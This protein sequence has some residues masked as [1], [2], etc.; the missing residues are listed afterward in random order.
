MAVIW[1]RRGRECGG[2]AVVA[3]LASFILMAGA[4]M[5]GMAD[6]AQALTLRDPDPETFVKVSHPSGLTVTMGV[7]GTDSDGNHY[8]CIEA[9]NPVDNEEGSVRRYQDDER[10]RRMAWILDRYRQTDQQTHAAIAILIQNE[11]GNQSQWKLQYQM[12]NA[13][14]P[15]LVERANRLWKESAGQVPANAVVER[16]DVSTP[17]GGEVKVHV[18]DYAGKP[19]AGVPFT[20]SL[21][22][23]ARFVDTGA[24]SYSG[25]SE[26]QPQSIAWQ[27]HGSGEVTARVTYDCDRLLI[28]ESSQDMLTL[29]SMSTVG[30]DAVT[31]L[32]RGG[33]RARGGHQSVR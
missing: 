30:G 21:Q 16:V 12:V 9:T 1:R 2:A 24:V 22:G 11:F 29:D 20:V 18:T 32:S 4:M 31:F 14:R 10:S 26:L 28:R 5:F 15:D 27:A 8:Y 33:V 23:P 25:V 7:M 19:I 3:A 13:V 17:R 6:T